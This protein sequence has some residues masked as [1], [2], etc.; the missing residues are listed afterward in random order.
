MNQN[1]II[2]TVAKV[3]P[4]GYFVTNDRRFGIGMTAAG[5]ILVTNAR[6][7]QIR[8]LGRFHNRVELYQFLKSK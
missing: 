4:R 3:S 6:S 8:T 5:I 2:N 1:E 7:T